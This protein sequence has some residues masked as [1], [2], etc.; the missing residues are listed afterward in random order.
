MA[1]ELAGVIVPEFK[2]IRASKGVIKKTEGKKVPEMDRKIKE[3][4]LSMRN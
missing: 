1:A 3:M 2:E 4:F